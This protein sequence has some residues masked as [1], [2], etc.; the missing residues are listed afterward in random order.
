MTTT[1][2]DVLSVVRRMK[3]FPGRWWLA[4]GWAIDAWLGAPSRDHED[5]EIGILRRDQA[6]FRRH[7]ARCVLEKVVQGPAGAHWVALQ[8]E[9]LLAAPEFQLQVHPSGACGPDGTGRGGGERIFEVFLND[10]RDGQWISRRHPTVTRALPELTVAS[11]LGMPVLAPE[12]Q[13]LYKAKYH[14]P[15][16][17]HDF[18]HALPHLT[19]DQRA[20]LRATVQEYH[21]GDPWLQAL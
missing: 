20:W 9:E 7:L 19:R 1:L 14:R 17:E 18:A 12:I 8:P 5:V 13:L 21:P 15:K 10:E 11:P 16:D 3:A 6:L 4:G 2:E